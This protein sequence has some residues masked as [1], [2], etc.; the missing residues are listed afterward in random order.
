[1]CSSD[2]YPK[3]TVKFQWVK[4]HA[5]LPGNERCDQLAIEAAEGSNLI[6]DEGYK[7]DEPGAAELF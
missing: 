2:L 7:P 5:G 4:G 1:M 3:H 6:P